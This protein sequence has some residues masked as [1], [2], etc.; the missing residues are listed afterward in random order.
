MTSDFEEYINQV[1]DLA[2]Q[3]YQS[4]SPT[5]TSH[6]TALWTEEHMS[7]KGTTIDRLFCDILI[8]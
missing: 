7:N 3:Y 2:D 1:Q 8:D 4:G 6:P 5:A